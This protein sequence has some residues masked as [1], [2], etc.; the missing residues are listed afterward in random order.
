MEEKKT[1]KKKRVGRPPKKV[2]HRGGRREGAG[3]PKGTGTKENPRNRMI[4]FRVSEV[5][6]NRMKQLRELTKD[7]TMPFVD[8]LEA[9]V[10]EMAQDYGIE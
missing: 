2:D 9:W 8:M 10:K 4:P 6:L 5:T 7:D 3:R 1:R